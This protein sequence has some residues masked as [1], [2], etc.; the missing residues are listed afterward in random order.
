MPGVRG[1]YITPWPYTATARHGHVLLRSRRR[2]S[3]GDKKLK[4]DPYL[5]DTLA[6]ALITHIEAKHSSKQQLV[7]AGPQLRSGLEALLV[8]PE[9]QR[10]LTRKAVTKRMEL[11]R[12]RHPAVTAGHGHVRGQAVI[13]C[14]A[15][16]QCHW[17]AA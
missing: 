17:L 9:W 13:P 8:S 10:A 5:W 15:T 3:A 16:K 11:V 12:D 1:L 7:R 4:W 14:K 2:S 6:P